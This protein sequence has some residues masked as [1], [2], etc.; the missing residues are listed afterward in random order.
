MVLLVGEVPDNLDVVGE[1]ARTSGSVTIELKLN[2]I[3]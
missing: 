2:D 3:T 1:P